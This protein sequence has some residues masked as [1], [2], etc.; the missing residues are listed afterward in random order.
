[1]RDIVIGR[2]NP[3]RNQ[4]D[5]SGLTWSQQ[6]PHSTSSGSQ[7]PSSPTI[8]AY[9]H[10]EGGNKG[11]N[12]SF[13]RLHQSQPTD[14]KLQKQKQPRKSSLIVLTFDSKTALKGMRVARGSRAS[15]HSLIFTS[16]CWIQREGFITSQRFLK[17]Q[18]AHDGRAYIPLVLLAGVV[19][20]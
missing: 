17:A 10:G 8:C 1:V 12:T 16:L 14:S 5:T 15:T 7:R 20:L 3:N 18:R 19:L 2:R 4:C 13:N 11:R 9:R 6:A